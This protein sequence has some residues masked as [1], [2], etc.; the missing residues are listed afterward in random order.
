MEFAEG[1]A[2]IV[3]ESSKEASRTHESGGTKASHSARES[4]NRKQRGDRPNVSRPKAM[5]GQK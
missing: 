5:A 2:K 3:V 4:V 1:D